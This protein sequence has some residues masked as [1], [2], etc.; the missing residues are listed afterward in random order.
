MSY[1]DDIDLVLDIWDVADPGFD[2]FTTDEVANELGTSRDIASRM[3]A[4]HRRAQKRG[5]TRWVA[6][7]RTYGPAATW[8]I[9][10][11]PGRPT[12]TAQR[13]SLGH[14]A[15]VANDLRRRALMDLTCELQPAAA[16]H[17]RCRR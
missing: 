8:Y 4:L 3:L 15:H 14:A 7:C 6:N 17:P 2:Q 5:T 11:G 9:L 12:G 10:G 13:L 1:A 16:S